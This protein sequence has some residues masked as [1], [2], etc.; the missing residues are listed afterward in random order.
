MGILR[1]WSFGEEVSPVMNDALGRILAALFAFLTFCYFL[2]TE[3][4]MQQDNMAQT[5]LTSAV[6]E[7]VDNARSS[8]KITAQSYEDL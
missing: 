2:I 7:F 4:A 8:G 5:Y 1:L 6:V 3:Q